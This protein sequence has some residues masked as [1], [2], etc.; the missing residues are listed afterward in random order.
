[1]SCKLSTLTQARKLTK[2]F[3][4]ED[5]TLLPLAANSYRALCSKVWQCAVIKSNLD[6][7]SLRNGLS[8]NL[9]INE[10]NPSIQVSGYL[11]LDTWILILS[12]YP[13]FGYMDSWISQFF[14][15]PDT[16]IHG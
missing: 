16:W 5:R 10:N 7:S 11:S 9:I 14:V 12:N 13:M 2:F 4:N 1:M 15:Y 3:A 8:F 6:T